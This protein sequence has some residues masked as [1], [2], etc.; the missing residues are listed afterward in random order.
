[1]PSPFPGM[2]PFLE[3]P[4]HWPDFHHRVISITSDMLAEQLRPKYYVRIEERVYIGDESDP[5]RTLI[6]PDLHLSARPGWEAQRLDAPERGGL[7]VEVE[8]EV[9]EPVVAITMIDEDVHEHRLEIIDVARRRVV[10]VIEVVSPSNKT[11]GSEGRASFEKKRRE[12]LRSPSHW[13]EIDLLRGGR[14]ITGRPRGRSCEYLVHVSHAEKR[15]R[16]LLWP[17]RLSQRLPVIPIPLLPDDP[18]AALDLEAVLTTAYDRAGY[19]LSVDYSGEPVP[20][21]PPEWL[22]WADGLLKKDALR[23]A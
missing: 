9:A 15:P 21:L 5:A 16:G 14:G 13:V 18:E 22:G 10:T 8:V 3:H 23:P 19:D 4:A 20:I 6:V 17:I 11:P 2:D 7:L 12:V 1:M